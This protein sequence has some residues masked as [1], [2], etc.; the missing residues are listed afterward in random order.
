MLEEYEKAALV[1]RAQAEGVDLAELEI[2]INFILQRRK[3]EIDK[4][5]NELVQKKAQEKKEALGPVCPSCGKQVPPMTL[6]C[7]CGYEFTK[8]EACSSAQ[9][10]AE[11]IEEINYEEHLSRSQRE[12]KIRNAI[13]TL[14]V[15]NTKEDI[16]ELLS[17][18]ASNL[19]SKVSFINTHK[20]RL[21]TY[22]VASVVSFG[23][24][25]IY[26]LYAGLFTKLDETDGVIREKRQNAWRQKCNQILLKGRS[27]RGDADFQR[28]LDY[29][30][31]LINKN[32]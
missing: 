16:L 10:L 1:K 20:G 27:L 2:Y 17:M 8:V 13:E 4:E 24:F 6:K 23:W 3:K 5:R 21:L 26:A 12:E 11:K 25:L 7:D 22:I 31:Q 15:P 19:Q 14:P 28:Q 18:G 32:K 29:Y 9:L 30:E